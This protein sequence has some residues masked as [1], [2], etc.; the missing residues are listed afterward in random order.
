M[1]LRQW[2]LNRCLK[3]VEKPQMARQ[4][5][6][7]LRAGFETKARRFFRVH[8]DVTVTEIA[9]ETSAG[10]MPALRLS[11]KQARADHILLY[12]HGG[13]FVMGSAQTHRALVS[14]IVAR[15]G[16]DAILPDYRLAPE[17]P[18]PAAFHDVLAAWNSLIDQGV[19]AG[20]IV[21][22]GDSA[23]GALVLSLLHYLLSENAKTPAAVF[24][25][26]PLTDMTFS[27]AS[28]ET[29]KMHDVL[30]P[31]Q[32]SEEMA[33]LYLK[34]ASA[35]DPLVSPLFGQFKNAPPVWLCVGDT[36]I[37]LDDV[38]RMAELL[39]SQGCD[40][41]LRIEGDLPHVWPIFHGW[42]PEAD[43]TLD[44]LTNWLQA[45]LSCPN[46]PDEN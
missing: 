35:K 36:E 24:G 44:A 20:K 13:G 1:S 22:G 5:P 9:I 12:V 38:R 27:G 15:A 4:T 40:A 11:R 30:L 31:A 3:L 2:C 37:L 46:Q 41:T 34:D 33:E 25:I 32:R 7:D 10:P 42:L 6:L 29:N 39:Q 23:G 16:C 21:L 19:P 8:K 28:F 14:Q 45:V 17:H 18:F 43:Q 26:S